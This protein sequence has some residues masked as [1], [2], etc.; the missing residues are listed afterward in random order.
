MKMNYPEKIEIFLSDESGRALVEELVNQYSKWYPDFIDFIENVASDSFM[1][2]F[3]DEEK[4]PME[5]YVFD[6]FLQNAIFEQ[7]LDSEVLS[8]WVILE[9]AGYQVV[10]TAYALVKK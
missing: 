1:S 7:D 9:R 2:G 8:L 4:H 5:K 3:I 10:P 6:C